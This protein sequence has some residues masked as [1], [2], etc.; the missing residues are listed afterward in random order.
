MTISISSAHNFAHKT[1]GPIGSIDFEAEVEFAELNGKELGQKAID[2]LLAYG[3]RQAFTDCY[4]QAKDAN[5]A[6]SMF[7]KKVAAVIA[8]KISLRE[9]L[10][11]FSRIMAELTDKAFTESAGMTFAAFA[12]SVDDEAKSDEVWSRFADSVR[13]QL[14]PLARERIERERNLG[15]K[16]QLSVK[17]LLKQVTDEAEET[18]E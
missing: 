7:D 18:S 8:G 6:R 15:E 16:L 14:E 17:D 10:D 1:F 11:T 5:K 12:K 4:S 9:K 2:Y 13:D 3:I